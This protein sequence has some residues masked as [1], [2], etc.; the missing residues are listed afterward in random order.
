MST[1]KFQ[2]VLAITM[3]IH[4]HCSYSWRV[5]NPPHEAPTDL[6]VDVTVVYP[7]LEDDF[8]GSERIV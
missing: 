6:T 8:G 1:V 4:M 5:A 7:C 3:A 2:I